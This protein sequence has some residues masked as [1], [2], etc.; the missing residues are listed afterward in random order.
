MSRNYGFAAEMAASLARPGGRFLDFGCGRGG[1]LEAALAQGF[2]AFGV[3]VKNAEWDMFSLGVRVPGRVALFSPDASLPFADGSF[4]V[5][6][7]NQVF[8]HV[9]EPEKALAELR[10]VL[11]PEGILLA[12][13]PVRETWVEPH[14][15]AP[16][17]HRLPEGSKAERRLLRL[18]RLLRGRP[19]TDA[20]AAEECAHV[21]RATFYR[22]EAEWRRIFGTA[23]RLH[24]RHE[25]AWLRDRL[26]GASLGRILP[27]GLG[28]WLSLRLAGACWSWRPLP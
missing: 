4:D 23:F 14:L 18:A 21:R 2:D 13:F 22:S 3:D 20:A 5:V 6:T 12:L 1:L 7:A 16:L 15:G 19:V 24:G 25:A 8:E 17:V 28:G 10:R 9:P 27:E 26:P 11:T